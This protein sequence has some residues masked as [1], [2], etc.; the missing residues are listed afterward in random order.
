MFYKIK[1]NLNQKQ[2][3][4]ILNSLTDSELN[5]IKSLNFKAFD[6]EVDGKVTSYVI[7]DRVALSNIFIF[8]RQNHIKFNYE[9][10]TEDVLIGTIT[11]DNTDFEKE[12]QE[13]VN[14]NITVDHILD[15]INKLGINSLSDFELQKLKNF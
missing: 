6:Q 14:E 3:D 15:K 10:I 5:Y 1:T 11:F 9:D 7:T 4:D 13:F 8:L 12:C 2:C